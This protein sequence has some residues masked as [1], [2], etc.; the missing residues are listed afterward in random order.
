MKYTPKTEEQLADESLLDDGLYDFEIIDVDDRPSKKGNDMITLKLAVFNN[1]GTQ[2][3]IYDYLVIGNPFGE[4]RLRHA[5]R[6]CGILD[7]YNSGNLTAQDF[8]DKSGRVLLKRQNGT[9]EYPA[10]KNIVSDYPAPG[11]DK[12]APPVGPAKDIINDDIPF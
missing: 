1:D 2:R 8:L 10:P 4:R 3:H 12:P 7:I 9:S 6:T 11:D 5:A